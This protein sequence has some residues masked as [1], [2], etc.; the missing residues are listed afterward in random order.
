[1][2]NIE[3]KI[4]FIQQEI[5]RI[6]YHKGTEHHIGKLKAK[7]ARLREQLE[8]TPV[9]GGGEGFA[10]KKSGDATCVLL[11]FPSVGKS[12]LLNKLTSAHSKVGHYK[13]TTLSVIPG[14]M[15][16][17]GAKI[18]ILDIPGLISG[19]AKGKGHGKQILSV[20]RNSDLLLVMFE[21]GKP[22]QLKK[23]LDELHQAGIHI[24][25][26]PPKVAVNKKQKGGIKIISPTMKQN[27]VRFTALNRPPK[28]DWFGVSQ[29][30][31]KEIAQEFGLVN[32][33]I[34]I[35][36]R[37]S[38]DQIIDVFSGNEVYLPALVIVNKID[39]LNE[40]LGRWR[41][42]DLNSSEVKGNTV[43]ISAEKEIGLEKLKE[44]IWKTLDLIR[45]YL[46]PE[47]EAELD[48]PLILKRGQTLADALKKIPPHVSEGV[49]SAL[50]WGPSAS[51]PGQ[52]IGLS[53]Q[54]LD[55]DTLTILVK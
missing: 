52:K 36:E 4:K 51:Y 21:V 9:R 3:E 10:V 46:K 17:K 31:I 35:K 14:M 1:M 28:A 23:A 33:E 30:T 48:K 38:L 41:G 18:Q 50:I 7:L 16:Y 49:K 26:S 6:P 39:L 44:Q 54:L 32:A 42:N 2:G 37:L 34:V 40:H 5:R 45:V 19:A 24:N 11:G 22:E 25:Q 43:F 29:K 20:A 53:H 47:R 13:F 12:T 27:E 8:K 15:E 55:Q